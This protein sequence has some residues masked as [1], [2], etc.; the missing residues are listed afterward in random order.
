MRGDILLPAQCKGAT[1]Q[2]EGG[3]KQ[4]G[5]TG[6]RWEIFLIGQTDK[7]ISSFPY[8]HARAQDRVKQGVEFIKEVLAFSNNPVLYASYFRFA[9]ALVSLK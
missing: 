7:V 4:Y 8:Q 2:R 1:N 9:F 6:P 5:H 3:H